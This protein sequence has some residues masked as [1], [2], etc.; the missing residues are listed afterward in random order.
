MFLYFDS[1][2][3]CSEGWGGGGQEE[4]QRNIVRQEEQRNIMREDVCCT[5]IIRLAL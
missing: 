3:G 1:L 2:L 4:E 5:G